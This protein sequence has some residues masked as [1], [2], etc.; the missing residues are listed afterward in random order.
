MIVL[1]FSQE[2]TNN[3]G[4]ENED[5]DDVNGNNIYDDL[6]K[7]NFPCQGSTSQRHNM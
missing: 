2:S 5:N 1:Q 3:D 6:M 4:G 7:F